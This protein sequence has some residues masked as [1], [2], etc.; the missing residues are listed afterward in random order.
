MATILTRVRRSGRRADRQA[1]VEAARP[2]PAPERA[3]APPLDIAPNDPLL[4]YL[5]SSPGPVDVEKLQLDSPALEHMRSMGLRLV[6]P[7]VAQGELIGMLNLGP[8]LSEQE[9]STDDRKLLENLAAQAAPAVRVAQLVREQEAEARRRERV[10]H[11]LQV[12]QLIQQNFLPKTTPDLPGWQVAAYYQPQ[13]AVG[14]D[15]YD[16]I[17]L[18]DGHLGLVIGDV[19]DKGVPAA[20]VMAATRSILRAAAPRLISPNEVLQR[21][22][23]LLCPDMPPNMFVTCL[24]GV[25]DPRTGHFRYANAGHNLPY[26]R[27]ADGVVEFRAT[28]LPLGLMPGMSYDEKE[29]VLGPG[30]TMLLSS[31]GLV[32]AHSP[33]GEMFGFPRLR[34]LMA[35]HPGGASL[36]DHLL[37]ELRR[38]VGP[39][40]DQEDDVTL[41]T[42]W[43]ASAPPMT[44]EERGTVP[45]VEGEPATATPAGSGRVLAE[46]TLPSVSGNE[47]LVMDRVAESVADVDIDD[48]RRERLKTAVSEAAMNAI[49]HGN[50]FQAELPVAVAV[51]LDG[52]NL[53]VRITDHGGGRDIP[54]AE[55]PDLDAKLEGK[56]TPRGWGLFLIKNMVDEMHVSS[57]GTHHSIELVLHLE[58]EEP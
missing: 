37:A 22:N 38:F 11:E 40:W 49:E 43:R 26:T 17:D 18:P 16:F 3:E 35:E 33:D 31:D 57:D 29:A 13:R 4:A 24:Y 1:P 7:L 12:A 5:Q 27:T 21:V 41:V 9:Y 36:L 19:T 44:I 28:G 46:F 51:S 25:L 14:G 39:A 32:E 10:E 8:R 34:E 52:R 55:T 30:Q 58:G 23:D 53:S 56:Q 47:R 15:F 2:A 20:L 54:E 50:R 42:L 45:D 48:T 6:V